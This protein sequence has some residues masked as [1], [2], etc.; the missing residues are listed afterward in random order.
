[1]SSFARSIIVVDDEMELATLFKAFLEKEGYNAVSF[2]DPVS[3]FEYFK[4]TSDKHSMIITDMRMP[5]MCGLDLAKRIREINDKIIIFLMTAFDIQ[6]VKDHP[7]FKFARIDR[8]IQKPI[9]LSDLR[10]MINTAWEN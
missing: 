8:L 10:E 1:M 4:E 7:H 2:T 9:R 6:D 5:G 3:A